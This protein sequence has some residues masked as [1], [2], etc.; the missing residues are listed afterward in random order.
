MQSL[1]AR[2][3][4][5]GLLP[6]IPNE[7]AKA[8]TA[9]TREQ[10]KKDSFSSPL[11]VE[12]QGCPRHPWVFPLTMGAYAFLHP[13]LGLPSLPLH[14]ETVAGLPSVAAAPSASVRRQP[15]YL[16]AQVVARR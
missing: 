8:K 16:V 15:V 7:V 12:H 14:K 13:D 6:I 5:S 3:G 2:V 4:P 10:R 11:V 9:R 1:A